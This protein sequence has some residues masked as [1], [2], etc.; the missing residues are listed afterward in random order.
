MRIITEKSINAFLNNT[1]FR[2]ANMSVH[3][4]REA[5]A[6][7]QTMV[8]LKLHGNTIAR[9][10]V[11]AGTLEITDAGWNTVTTRSRLNGLPGV[12]VYNR[13]CELYLNGKLWDGNWI[14]V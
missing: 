12:R 2:L 14:T 13:K 11:T 9:K 6:A 10:N 8:Y 1:S 4:E 5:N 3:V 7:G